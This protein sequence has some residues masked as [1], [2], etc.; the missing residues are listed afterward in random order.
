[1]K[2]SV[3]I[4]GS[5]SEPFQ[6]LSGL[7]QGFVLAPTLF[8]IFFSLLLQYA[9]D[10]SEDGIYIRTRSDGNLFNLA[11]LRAKT[12]L[13]R[14]LLREML[15]ADDAALAA[16]SEESLQRLNDQLAHACKEFGL[17]ISLKKT[18]IM[19]QDVSSIPCISIGDHTL[20]VVED[21]AYLGSTISS[22]LS[23][24]AEL[25]TRIGKAAT[26][27]AR[28]TKRVWSNAMLSTNTKMRI[29][30][31]CVVS[32]L[33]YGSES[34]TL[35]SRQERRLKTFHIRCLRKVLGI[36]WQ[37]HV[38]NKDVLAKANIPTM[39][40]LLSLRRLRWLG[41]VTG[42]QDGRIPKDI[43]HGEL[44]TGTRPT[45]RLH[46]RFKDVCKRDIKPSSINPT[47]HKSTATDRDSW[48]FKVKI[49]VRL[50]EEKRI[51]EWE[52]K[53]WRRQL[54]APAAATNDEAHT[55]SNCNKTCGSGIRLLSHSRRCQNQP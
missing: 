11:R 23:L 8:G 45:G 31:A 15:F 40:G 44:K 33:L 53:R 4:N 35:Y 43:L 10:G 29:Y 17:T 32:T 30:E 54:T 2:G 16:H 46:L 22:N 37:D 28:L 39:F 6:I 21:F 42:M 38:T 52:D 5:S 34:W 27:M 41:H 9:F 3:K 12:K 48:S 24:D 7:K 1:M 50:S 13:W 14:V 49:S 19:G 18:N 26:A 55:C 20:E 36:V 25:S 51:A 47:N